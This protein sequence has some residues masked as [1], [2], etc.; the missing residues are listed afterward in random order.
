MLFN[1]WRQ[2]VLP[3]GHIGAAWR[4]RLN[5]CIPRPTR[6]HNRNGKSVQPF[7]HS[8][9]QKVP[10]L[11]KGHAYPPELPFPI[12]DLDVPCNTMLWAHASP[13]PKRHLDRFSRVFTDDR[14][15]SLYW[16]ACFP[17]KI[18]PSHVGIWTSCNTWFIG[19]TRVQNANGNL[20]VSVIFAGLTS[21]TDWQS[22]RQTTLLGARRRNNA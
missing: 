22:D 6:V 5:L 21:A 4:I 13:Q 17:L 14:R 16:F 18:V 1:R 9:L 10:V 11:Y 19:P 12:G 3:W 2:C 15:V 8:L 20:L 7:F